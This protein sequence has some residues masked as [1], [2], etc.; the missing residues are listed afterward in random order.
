ME[1]EEVRGPLVRI[2]GRER[3]CWCSNDYLGLSAH[4]RLIDAATK[5]AETWGMGARASRLLAGTTPWHQRLEAA[6]AAWCGQEAAI[7]YT[8]GYLANL[9]TLRALLTTQDVVLVDRLAHASLIDAARATSATFRVFHHNDPDHLHQLLKRQTR[10]RRRLIVTEGVFSMDGDR[11]PLAALAEVATT[12][13]ALIYLDDAH[14][15]F[16]I[17]QTGRGAPEAAGLTL[18]AS[19]P[20]PDASPQATSRPEGREVPLRGTASGGGIIYMGTL[21]KA[22]GAQGGFVVGPSRLIDY[23]RNRS[24]PFI[25][26]TALAVPVA[27]A[28]TEALRLLEED[29]TARQVLQARTHQLYEGLKHLF[30]CPLTESSH[31]LPLMLG[32]TSRAIEWS[33]RLWEQGV[34]CPPIRPPTVPDGQARLRLSVTALH[35]ADQISQLL[36]AVE[37]IAEEEQTVR[38]KVKGKR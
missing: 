12:H 14:G 18:G 33:Q 8:S 2:Q 23:L 3:V 26:A 21:G 11:A 30:L 19:L 36:N 35:T 38:K 4:P 28:A 15:A 16:V 7:V 32:A 13:D 34:W 5:A 10:A 37:E 1:V 20:P 6:L 27:A 22:L 31:I 24:R 17:G 9:G 25:Y 29:A